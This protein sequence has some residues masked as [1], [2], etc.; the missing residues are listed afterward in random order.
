MNGYNASEA[1]ITAI[2]RRLDIDADEHITF[3]EFSAL[4]VANVYD[5]NEN[6]TNH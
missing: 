3:H 4:M 6:A 1:E 5:S 2:V